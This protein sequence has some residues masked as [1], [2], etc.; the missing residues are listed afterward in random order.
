MVLQRPATPSCEALPHASE[1][2]WAWHKWDAICGCVTIRGAIVG[3]SLLGVPFVGGSLLG[4]P[5]VGVAQVGCHLW[6][7]HY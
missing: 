1:F 3:G 6:V 5:F 4:V 2:V 7:C